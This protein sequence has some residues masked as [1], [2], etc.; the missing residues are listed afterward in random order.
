VTA[1]SLPLAHARTGHRLL[2]QHLISCPGCGKPAAAHVDPRPGDRARLVRL[3]CPE[4]C[5][6]HEEAVLAR[7]PEYGE[8]LSA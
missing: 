6:V 1:E 3:V 5:A 4:A 2:A 7:L 8:V